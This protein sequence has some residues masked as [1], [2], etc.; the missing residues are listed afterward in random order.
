M[1][2][3]LI[4]VIFLADAGIYSEGE[5]SGSFTSHRNAMLK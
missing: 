1:A 4:L 2:S 3:T 5:D